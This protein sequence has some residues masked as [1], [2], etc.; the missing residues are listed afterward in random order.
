MSSLLSLF[1]GLSHFLLNAV[2]IYGMLT[3]ASGKNEV[4]L[5]EI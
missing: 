3:T 2:C 1:Q 5:E 4:H